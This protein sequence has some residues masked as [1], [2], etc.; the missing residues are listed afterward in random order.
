MLQKIKDKVIG[1]TKHQHCERLYADRVT[2]HTPAVQNQWFWY[3][4]SKKIVTLELQKILLFTSILDPFKFRFCLVSFHLI[5]KWRWANYKLCKFT[6]PG[7]VLEF[8]N[9]HQRKYMSSLTCY[10]QA[11]KVKVDIIILLYSKSHIHT[12]Q[13][14]SN[15]FNLRFHGK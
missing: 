13:P 2:D 9:C 6:R 3:I 4:F 7:I 5:T 14:I 11:E 15:E 1:V 8:E 10:Q 12:M